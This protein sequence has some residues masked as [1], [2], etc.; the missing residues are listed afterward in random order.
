MYFDSG[1]FFP[2]FNLSGDTF[3]Q[4]KNTSDIIFGGVDQTGIILTIEARSEQIPNEGNVFDIF[5]VGFYSDYVFTSGTSI[6]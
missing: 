5:F 2:K 4:D 6:L 1:F 3:R